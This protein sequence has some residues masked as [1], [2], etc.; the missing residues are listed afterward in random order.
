MLRVTHL[1][2]NKILNIVQFLDSISSDNES[3][4][5][6]SM[7][8]NNR[9]LRFWM[10]FQYVFLFHRSLMGS[11]QSVPSLENLIA[12]NCFVSNQN[13]SKIFQDMDT[14]NLFHI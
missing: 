1:L 12:Y 11:S 7:I 4:F 13:L 10:L 2:T 8:E 6:A 3:N 9:I 5:K 14:F